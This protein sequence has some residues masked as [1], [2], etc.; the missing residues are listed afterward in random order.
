VSERGRRMGWTKESE[1]EAE[2]REKEER[3]TTI[4]GWRRTGRG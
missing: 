4:V 2:Q 1:R 3:L